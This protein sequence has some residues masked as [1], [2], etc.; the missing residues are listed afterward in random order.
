METIHISD[1]S[2]GSYA[3]QDNS[4]M[5]HLMPLRHLPGWREEE[6]RTFVH[7]GSSSLNRAITS[8]S[9]ADLSKVSLYSDFM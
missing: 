7:R 2:Q 3:T 5:C 1:I 4:R 6:E 9:A 8:E